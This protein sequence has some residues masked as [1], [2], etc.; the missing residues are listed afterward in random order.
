MPTS[1]KKSIRIRAI[2]VISGESAELRA[3]DVLFACP[4]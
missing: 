3:A 2:R 1:G 4:P